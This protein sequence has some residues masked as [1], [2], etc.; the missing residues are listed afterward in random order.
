MAPKTGGGAKAPSAHP[1]A[2]PVLAIDGE[3]LPWVP[4]VFLASVGR[5]RPEAEP[6]RPNA[7]AG[8]NREHKLQLET[9]QEKPLAPRVVNDRR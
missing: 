6:G 1:S 2:V 8:Q 3:R 4:E 7:D 5:N 9:A